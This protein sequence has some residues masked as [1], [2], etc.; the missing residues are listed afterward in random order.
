[1]V[2]FPCPV[3]WES[4]GADL[5]GNQPENQVVIWDRIVRNKREARINLSGGKNKYAFKEIAETFK[6]A[7][8]P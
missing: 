3:L 7:F 1:M 2:H 8:A 5:S 6:F 4:C